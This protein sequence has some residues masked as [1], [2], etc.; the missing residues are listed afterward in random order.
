MKKPRSVGSG[1]GKVY[2]PRGD[3][4][5]PLVTTT[6]VT[7]TM[8]RTPCAVVIAMMFEVLDLNAF[9]ACSRILAQV[10]LT[11]GPAFVN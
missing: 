10:N 9:T 4:V 3:P 5:Q 11:S 8:V 2:H 7:A 6:T 1:V